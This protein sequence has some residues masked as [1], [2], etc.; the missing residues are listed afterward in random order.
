MANISTFA[1]NFELAY[2]LQGSTATRPTAWGIGLSLG[3]PT[4]VSASEIAS[5]TGVVRLAA[6]FAS[7]NANTFT[8]T[9]AS[10]YGPVNA[11]GS[12]SGIDVFDTTP[13]SYTANAG[14]YLLGGLLATARTVG[15]GDSLVLGSGALSVSL[16]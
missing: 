4:S 11:A 14:N 9:A 5:G 10:T 15:S 7:Q 6:G 13:A 12:Y 3:S 16:T 1:A 8:Q 2:L